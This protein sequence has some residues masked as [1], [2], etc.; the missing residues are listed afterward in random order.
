MAKYLV[1]EKSV[2]NNQI[3]EAGTVV[4]YTPP[5]GVTVSA[6]LEP[7]KE[8]GKHQPDEEEEKTNPQGPPR[9]QHTF[10]E[11]DKGKKK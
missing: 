1:K 3:Y 5:E 7:Y 6:N 2:I 8:S 9:A 11:E 4:D 10:A